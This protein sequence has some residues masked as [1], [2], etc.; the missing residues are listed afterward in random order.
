MYYKAGTKFKQ[1]RMNTFLRNLLTWMFSIGPH[2]IE[3]IN[4]QSL[5]SIAAT[6]ETVN[7][8]LLGNTSNVGRVFLPVSMVD[9][10][11]YTQTYITHIHNDNIVF[12]KLSKPIR[13]KYNI[14][15][16]SLR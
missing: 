12:G 10:H 15:P 2:L 11:V 7:C 1:S 14:T 8:P 5:T 6:S 3:C 13:A 4:N 9:I 16:Q